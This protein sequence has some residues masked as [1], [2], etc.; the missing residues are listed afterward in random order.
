[1]Y[2]NPWI[3]RGIYEEVRLISIHLERE[4]VLLGEIFPELYLALPRVHPGIKDLS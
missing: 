4:E 3:E 2:H 1:M